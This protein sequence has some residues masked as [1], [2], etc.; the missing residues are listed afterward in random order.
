MK[1]SS[2]YF[3]FRQYLL[4]LFFLFISPLCRAQSQDANSIVGDW[5]DSKKETLVRCY[6]V[7]DKFYAK[8][9]W[10]ENEL[11]RGKPLPKEEQHWI[12]M[13]VMKNFEYDS[14]NKEWINGTIYQPKTDK[15]YTA[16]L[17]LKTENVLQVTGYLWLRILS[18]NETFTRVKN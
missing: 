5:M 18:E 9:L 1:S 17:K 10:V 4:I 15:T 12:N 3:Q 2:P 7:G 13:I 8:V 16:Y 11:D 6:R 14:N